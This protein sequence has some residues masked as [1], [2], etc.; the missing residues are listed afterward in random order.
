MSDYKGADEGHRSAL[1]GRAGSREREG[2]QGLFLTL[3]LNGKYLLCMCSFFPDQ[4]LILVGEG[5]LKGLM[6]IRGEG[7]IPPSHP[8]YCYW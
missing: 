3:D 2:D 8:W 6:E 5:E 4:F 7:Q 1:E